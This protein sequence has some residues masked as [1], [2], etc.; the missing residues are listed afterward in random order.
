M[1]FGQM[2]LAA[3]ESGCFARERMKAER[4]VSGARKV[5]EEIVW[6][7]GETGMPRNDIF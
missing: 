1:F 5:G 7:G 4:Q 3:F 6:I 2:N